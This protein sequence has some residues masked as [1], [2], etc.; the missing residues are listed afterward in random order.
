MHHDN[1]LPTVRRHNIFEFL[2]NK[3][4]QSKAIYLYFFNSALSVYLRKSFFNH[5]QYNYYHRADARVS[6]RHQSLASC[7]SL[8][9]PS[10]FDRS[11]Q[12]STRVAH[13]WPKDQ[14]PSSVGRISYRDAPLE[15]PFHTAGA[16]LILADYKLE[17]PA[18]GTNRHCSE[19]N[20][21]RME[22]RRSA[23]SVEVVCCSSTP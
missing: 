7:C 14:S 12:R 4:K 1:A 19:I 20:R 23:T 2:S 17:S 9:M 15:P 21:P 5:R 11:K 8:G 10:A 18:E 16:C 6:P 22:S 13:I 3:F